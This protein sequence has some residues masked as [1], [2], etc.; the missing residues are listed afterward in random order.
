MAWTVIS[1][2]T[3]CGKTNGQ[4]LTAE[5]LAGCNIEALIAGGHIT[6]SKPAGKPARA[7]AAVDPAVDVAAD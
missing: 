1:T 6:P 4:T 7:A 2:A 3:V 5:D